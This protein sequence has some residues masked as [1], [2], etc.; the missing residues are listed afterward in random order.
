MGSD[1]SE[2]IVIE[3]LLIFVNGCNFEAV[4]ASPSLSEV[5]VLLAL[6]SKCM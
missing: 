2:R 1:S 3:N 4:F 6:S 5:L